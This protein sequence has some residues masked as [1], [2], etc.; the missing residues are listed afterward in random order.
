MFD[1]L[2]NGLNV[3]GSVGSLASYVKGFALERDVEQL[4]ASVQRIAKISEELRFARVEVPDR[5]V[6]NFLADLSV[7]K[8]FGRSESPVQLL[9]KYEEALRQAFRRQLGYWGQELVG[10]LRSLS[11]AVQLSE[12]EPLL[13]DGDLFERVRL[14]PG[15][16]GVSN[17]AQV[18][19]GRIWHSAGGRLV[20]RA[21]APIFWEDPWSRRRFMGTVP[22][23][24]FRRYGLHIEPPRYQQAKDGFVY[25]E[26]HGLYLPVLFLERM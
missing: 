21:S 5:L 13:V 3:L 14:D 24:T 4:K 18:R 22:M 8:S 7:L 17:M 6:E 1:L 26:R 10:E 15:G 11:E 23:A 25:S 12:T 2:L 9:A 16:M 19:D 20:T